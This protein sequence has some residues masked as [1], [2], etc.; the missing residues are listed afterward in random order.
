MYLALQLD[1][2]R[3]LSKVWQ[4][5]A[6]CVDC[7]VVAWYFGLE[8]NHQ[9][10]GRGR[11]GN[12]DLI[13]TFKKVRTE[14]AGA[15]CTHDRTLLHIP[16]ARLQNTLFGFNW[17]SN[18]YLPPVKASGKGQITRLLLRFTDGTSE[19]RRRKKQKLG[20]SVAAAPILS[21]IPSAFLRWSFPAPLIL[22]LE[23]CR[24]Q[25]LNR[26]LRSQP[27]LGLGLA[28]NQECIALANLVAMSGGHYMCKMREFFSKVQPTL[29]KAIPTNSTIVENRASDA[30]CTISEEGTIATSVWWKVGSIDLAS[31]NVCWKLLGI[32]HVGKKCTKCIKTQ[33]RR[34]KESMNGVC[35]QSSSPSS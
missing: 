17:G 4:A 21:D 32:E 5:D 30:C 27:Q 34:S 26:F 1:V 16:F 19:N 24:T 9:P 23:T 11:I 12:W 13:S 6:R 22:P 15:C 31:R 18:W 7:Y 8:A 20:I 28:Q 33:R 3:V 10:Q 25:E 29:C 35:E 14:T 2:Q